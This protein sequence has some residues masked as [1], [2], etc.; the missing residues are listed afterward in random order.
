[1]RPAFAG[2]NKEVRILIKRFTRENDDMDDLQRHKTQRCE[3]RAATKLN[4]VL[5]LKY[6]FKTKVGTCKALIIMRIR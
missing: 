4:I 2:S 6:S 3:S 1:M 5:R